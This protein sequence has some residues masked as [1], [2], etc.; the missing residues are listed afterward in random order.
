MVHKNIEAH[1]QIDGFKNLIHL[2]DVFES[3]RPLLRLR[4]KPH[5]VLTPT[6]TALR[7]EERSLVAAGHTDVTTYKHLLLGEIAEFNGGADTG[8]FA[9]P[10]NREDYRQQ[11]VSDMVLFALSYFSGMG[12]DADGEPL[13]PNLERILWDTGEWIDGF[14]IAEVL[15]SHPP[16]R[17]EMFDAEFDEKFHALKG[18]LNKQAHE[19]LATKVVDFGVDEALKI[20]NIL[21]RIIAIC[22]A[23]FHLMG[24]NPIRQVAEKIARNYYRHPANLLSIEYVPP[25]SDDL[26]IDERRIVIEERYR[27]QAKKAHDLWDGPATTDANGNPGPRPGDGTNDFYSEGEYRPQIE[28]VVFKAATSTTG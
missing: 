24:V 11:E 28:H 16:G 13:E 18:Y 23:I 20:K 15:M 1:E 26:P 10:E 21:E 7:Y 4:N 3:D 22:F 14:K 6:N 12:L 27:T 9:E 19:L 25:M 17:V 5:L 2:N 8:Y